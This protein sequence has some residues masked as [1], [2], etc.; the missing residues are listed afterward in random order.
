MLSTVQQL[1]RKSA[2]TLNLEDS[3]VEDIIR[4]NASHNFT[5]ELDNGDKFQAFRLQHSN[6]RGPYKGGIRFHQDVDYDEVQALATV[7]SLKTALVDI[8]MG[9]GKGGVVVN[10][11]KLDKKTLEEI[12]RKYVRGLV[13]HIGPE[14]DSP[15]PDVNTN[16][17]IMDWMADE[18]SKLTGD[19]T[20]A[21]F[22][23]KSL[24]NGGSEGRGEATAMGGL[25]VFGKHAALKNIEY[26]NKTYAIEGFGNAGSVYA[27]LMNKYYPDWKLV[28]VSDTSGVLTSRAGLDVDELIEFKRA[29]NRFKDY[30]SEG[31]EFSDSLD[32]ATTECDLLVFAALGGSVTADNAG[33]VRATTVLELANGPVD[34]DAEQIL[35]DKGVHTLPDFLANA[36]GVVVSYFEWYQNMNSEHWTQEDVNFKLKFI[37]EKATYDVLMESKKRGISTKDAAYLLA[38]ERLASSMELLKNESTKS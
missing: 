21:S 12:A 24:G 2:K 34:I 28:S 10:P 25:F 3:L 22:T 20:K 14:T 26:K 32:I 13:D 5:I 30:D 15:A 6:A 9:G 31:V 17:Q 18:Y 19:S 8:P 35:S 38:V 16:P 36:G 7:M 1:I 27:S 29:R 37:M 33:D 23:G 4:P 11:K